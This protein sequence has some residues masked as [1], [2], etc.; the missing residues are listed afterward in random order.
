ML[1]FFD[2]QKTL[3]SPLLGSIIGDNIA[4]VR[5]KSDVG[6]FI[7]VFF[8]QSIQKARSLVKV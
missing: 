6:L 1:S 5:K 7:C 4:K 3:I 8:A 2:P